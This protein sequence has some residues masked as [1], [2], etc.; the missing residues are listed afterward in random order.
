MD[1]GAWQVTK[2]CNLA[3]KHSERNHKENKT[4]THRWEKIFANNVIK[5]IN[6]QNLQTV[7][8]AKYKKNNPIKKWAEV[9]TFL[10]EYRWP[11]GI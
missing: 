3:H 10:Q 4:T 5:G 9:S 11:R 8:V 1:R 7:H 2:S 6:L